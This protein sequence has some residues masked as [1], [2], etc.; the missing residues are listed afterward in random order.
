MRRCR[1][2]AAGWPTGRARAC[3][4][5]TARRPRRKSLAWAGIDN[6]FYWIDPARNLCAAVMMQFFP[7]VDDQA[8][9]LLGDF[10]K[11]AYTAF[12]GN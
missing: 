9:G 3:P 6:T 8:V 11:A 10:E 1:I 12:A 2:I 7:F 5:C 4:W